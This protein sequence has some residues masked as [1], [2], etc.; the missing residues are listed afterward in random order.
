M[1]QT[2][3]KALAPALEAARRS[4]SEAVE[5][6]GSTSDDSPLTGHSKSFNLSWKT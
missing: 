5:K 1:V 6:T 3:R 4:D 2:L